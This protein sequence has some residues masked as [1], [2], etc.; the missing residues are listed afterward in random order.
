MW[1]RPRTARLFGFEHRLEA[2]VP[3]DKRVHG[4]FAMPVLHGGRLVARVDPKRE[5]RLLH[6]RR[7]TFETRRDGRVPASAVSGTARALREA[8]AWVECDD[9]AVGDVVPAAVAG[10][11][12][13]ELAR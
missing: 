4:Y 12:A 11:L 10:P 1:H 8:A 3:A 2:Y 6:A 13:T 7:V 9:V 5:G